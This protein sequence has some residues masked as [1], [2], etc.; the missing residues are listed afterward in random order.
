[1]KS[2]EGVGAGPHPR[3]GSLAAPGPFAFKSSTFTDRLVTE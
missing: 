2:G 1:M 3:A